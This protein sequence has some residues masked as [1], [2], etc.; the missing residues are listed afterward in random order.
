MTSKTVSETTVH[1]TEWQLPIDLEAVRKGLITRSSETVSLSS[2][3]GC[4]FFSD[5]LLRCESHSHN[6]T[7][8]IVI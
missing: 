2:K 8:Y 5:P 7:S 6:A 3:N 1:K 4:R